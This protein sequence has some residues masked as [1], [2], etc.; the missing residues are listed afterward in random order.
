LSRVGRAARNLLAA[1]G[2]L[3]VIVAF[4][5]LTSWWTRALMVDWTDADGDIL[6]VLGAD[7]PN[8][9]LIGPGS[10]WRTFYSVLAW[11]QGHFRTIIVSGGGDV[12]T[13]MRDL[14]I[15][16]GVPAEHIVLEP[17]AVNTHENAI[18]T[19]AL[20][21][22]MSGRK[23]LLTSDYHMYRAYWCFRR[24][25]VDVIPRPVPEMLKRVSSWPTRWTAAIELSIETAKIVGYRFRGWI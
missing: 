11:R 16:D 2:L 23:V 1:I 21:R 10:Y 5:P 19:A 25:G 13:S 15:S 20:V 12:G 4:T 3:W 18:R 7:N 8:E 9:T 14:L 6:I 22:E 24:A 17:L